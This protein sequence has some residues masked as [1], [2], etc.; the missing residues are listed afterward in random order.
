MA[1]NTQQFETVVTL[2]AQ[3]AQNQLAKMEENLKKLRKDKA[4]LLSGK[5]Y[6]PEDLR[7]LNKEIR[8]AEGLMGT[9]RGSITQ[10]IKTLSDLDNASLGEIQ[11][12][13]RNLKKEMRNVTSEDEYARMDALLQKANARIIQLKSEAG[14]TA[15][16][17][18]RL[19]EAGQTTASVLAN[20]E[21]ASLYDLKTAAA[22]LN[23]EMLKAKPASSAYVHAEENLH[24]V[25]DRIRSLTEGQ[26]LAAKTL[27]QYNSEAN[28]ITK[29]QKQIDAENHIIENTIKNLSHSSLRDLEASLK[30]VKEQMG[31][32]KDRG[33]AG[34]KELAEKARK[35]DSEIKKVNESISGKTGNVF[36]RWWQ[37]LNNN[38]GAMTQAWGAFTGLT[39][40]VRQTTAAF[41]EMDQEMVNV[42]KYTG[43]TKKE[44]VAMNEDFKRMNTRTAREELNQLAGSAGRLGITATSDIEE[45]VDAADKI[46][47]ALGDDLGEKAV[48]QIGKLAMMFGE[49]KKKGLRGAM[50]STGSAINE[51]AQSSSASAGYLVD[52][53]ARLSG[54]GKQAGLTQQ[55]I[56]GFASVLDQN[57]QQDE[58]AAT[59]M[60]NL[61][62]KMFQQPAKFAAL[63]GKSVKEFT[64]LLKNDANEALIQFFGAM[65]KNGGFAQLAPMFDEMKMDGSRAV[66]VLSV[67]ADKL[68]DV[69]VAQETANRAYASGQ[70]VIDEFNTQM[71]SQQAA[72]DMAKKDFKEL[73]IELGEQLLPVVKYTISTG[74]LLVKSLLTI[75]NFTRQHY[76]GIIAL[77]AAIATIA[78]IYYLS[79]IKVKLWAAAQLVATG[80]DKLATFV[81]K[82]Q[83]TVVL[84][85]KLAYYAVTGQIAKCRTTMMAMRAAS[86]AN[87]YAALATALLVLVAA[88]YKL[89]NMFLS[90]KKAMEGNML[91]V[92]KA[93][94]VHEDMVAATKEMNEN[95]AEERTRV[96][97]LTKI[98]NSNVYS[99]NE[100]KAAM[101][102]LEKIVP[103]F[104]RNLKNEEALT[105][106]NN[107]AL[108]EYVRKLND[109]ALAQALYNKMVALQ[110]K[111]FDLGREIRKHERSAKAVRAEIARHPEIY[112]AT[113]K[114]KQITVG[115]GFISNLY[116][117][118][119]APTKA[120][121][122]KHAELQ[123]WLNWS[124]LLKKKLAVVNYEIKYIGDYLKQNEG[125]RTE[126]HKIVIKETGGGNGSSG[127][128]IPGLDGGFSTPGH[129]KDPKQVEKER[130][131]AESE[132]EKAKRLAE[133]NEREMSKQRKQAYQEAI[134]EARGNTDKEQA[135][136]ILA[137]SKG[138]KTF[139]QYLDDQHSIAIEGYRKLEAIYKQYG[140]DYG[141]WQDEIAKEELK[142]NEDHQKALLS[143]I[144]KGRVDREN[145]AKEAYETL[146]SSIYHDEKALN[147]LLFQN[148]MRALSQRLEAMEKGTQEWFDTRSEMEQRDQEHRIY[149]HQYYAELLSHYQE[150]WGKADLKE[151]E[152]IAMKGIEE[153]YDKR[154]IK[155]QEYQEA[156]A[157]IALQYR[158]EQSEQDV[159]HSDGMWFH[160]RSE[161][162]YQTASNNANADYQNEHPFGMGVKDWATADVKIYASTLANL[163][164]MEQEGVITHEEAMAAMGRATAEMA[165]GIASKMQAAYDAVSPI[166]DAM[167]SYY[168]AQSDYEVTVTEKKYEKLINAAGNNQA[169]AKKLEEKKEKEIAAIKTKYARK[170]SKM[171]VAQAIAQT[172]ISA[173]SAY[174]SAMAGVPYPANLVLAPIAA[175]LALAA[176]AIQIAT[177]KKQQQAQEAGY[178]EGGFTGG[179]SYR[180]RAGVV[181]EGEFVANHAAVNNPQLLPALRLIDMAQRNNTVGSLT[182]LDLSRSMGVGATTVVSAPVVNVT[183]NNA[184]L[185]TALREACD[186]IERLGALLD[187]G[188]AANVSMEEFKKKERHWNSIHSNR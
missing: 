47:V 170:Q 24:K 73:A 155:W 87:P 122:K 186:T 108:A 114:G 67:I 158:K 134:K 27:E 110:G 141:Q 17:M 74:A 28:K 89:Y 104:H 50:L 123:N 62:T 10:T 44:V 84:G 78:S 5:S 146:G 63:A 128:V 35:L 52:F 23:E 3:Q 55:Q 79:T 168:S 61:I 101:I 40:T 179:R 11:T 66:G 94:A 83:T 37:R 98:I 178:Y 60:Q 82:T 115:D 39:D 75:I 125:V 76:K 120:N 59:A 57:M 172:A 118:Y 100:K 64:N 132:K 148:D 21:N 109:A 8:Q 131:K 92:R 72:L 137:Y 32:F 34:F 129:Y 65:R 188:I 130:K 156:R 102:A 96:E 106:S 90:S 30:M 97:E 187:G 13:V 142:K 9:Y 152:R 107:E 51:L 4:E 25:N 95:T 105:R 160:Q 144:E 43:Q 174:S 112:N 166:M 77:S 41:A 68:A 150:Q 126:Y 175:G 14:E 163:K 33:D 42:Q 147:E 124:R 164:K 136:N 81:L 46:N 135:M 12:A 157:A 29:T 85:L 167:S 177:I 26:R 117:P 153:L 53:T 161:D 93:K 70:S 154:L 2:N 71:S 173:I 99:Y 151:Q 133:K 121:R 36:G 149:L 80:I 15:Q 162:A 139:T 143:D 7:E 31:Q 88:G 113:E 22:T 182:A 111:Q 145:K 1:R 185:A 119:S 183:T 127:V 86:I 180:R 176:G 54:V 45:F 20:I 49:D 69:K 48:D 19:A 169:K 16:E 58:T 138:E 165:A 103:G 18:R 140:T 171:Q 184:E 181:H 116:V 38:W 159:G 91:S 56:M 6:N